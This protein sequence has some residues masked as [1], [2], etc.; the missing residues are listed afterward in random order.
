MDNPQSRSWYTWLLVPLV[1][2]AVFAFTEIFAPKKPSADAP[3]VDDST[4]QTPAGNQAPTKAEDTPIVAPTPDE[5][6][7]RSKSESLVTIKNDKLAVTFTSLNAAIQKVLVLG[8]RYED[9]QTRQPFQLVTTDKEQYLPGRITIVGAPQSAQSTWAVT[10]A[11]DNK[12]VFETQDGA[13]SLKRTWS[14]GPSSYK[15]LSNLSVTNVSDAAKKIEID[16]STAHYVARETESGGFLNFRPSPALSHGVCF[17][18]DETV[19]R[20][21][22]AIIK[23][24]GTEEYGP[25]VLFAGIE[26]SYFTILLAPDGAPAE[27]CRIEASDRGG[28]VDDPLGSLFETTLRYKS[29]QLAPGQTQEFKTAIYAGPKDTD[30]LHA[31]GHSAYE[32]ID[33]GWFSIIADGLN[34]SLKTIN[35]YVHNWGVAIIILVIFVKLILFPLNQ[36]A[37]GAMAKQRKLKPEMD[38]INELYKDDPEKK[39]A[40]IME[41]YRKHKVNPV[42]GCLPMFL[43]MPIWLALYQSLLTNIELYRA[44]FTS[45]WTD[46][47]AP[48][49]Y[50]ILPLLWGVLMFLQQKLTPAAASMEPMQQKIMMYGMPVIFTVITLF[51]PLGLCLYW[52]T[53]SIL[54]IAQQ[55]YL[56]W[57]IDRDEELAANTAE[58]SDGSAD[59]IESAI[60][61]SPTRKRSRRG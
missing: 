29:V 35:G 51:L 52:V 23:D 36:K 54:T 22:K 19:R 3:A 38:R 1:V 42:G 17:A 55:K 8:A 28:T 39:G 53:N 37:F 11:T 43:Q 33:L 6:H 14:F 21:R 61:N 16:L 50:F 20:D 41:L 27:H 58:A 25:D 56:Y 48:D 30:A 10:E 31:F 40:A 60:Q 13:L 46:L 15:L 47:S 7:A 4:T 45:W 9:P 49:P 5:L 18:D 44:P 32:V 57:K 26:N 24:G 59:S 12:I 2:V 34:W